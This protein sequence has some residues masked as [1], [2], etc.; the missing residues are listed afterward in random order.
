MATDFR[1]KEQLTDLT[2]QIVESYRD[3]GTINHLG[4]CPLPSTTVIADALQDLKEV[5]YPGYRRRQNLHLGNVTYYAGDLIDSLHD[6]LTEQIAR[7]LRYADDLTADGSCDAQK[8]IDYEAAGQDHAIRLL[9]SLPELRRMLAMDVQAA[10]DGDPA[11]GGLDEIIFCY[12]GLE[13]I[14]IHRIA[15]QLHQQG[16]PLIPRIMAEWS[17]AQTGIDIHPGAR[18]GESFF[19]DHGTGVVIGETTDIAANVKIYQGVTL[20][21]ISFPRDSEGNLLRGAKRHPTIEEGVVIYANA[22]I[23][24]GKTVIGSNSVIG[25]SVS[26]NKSVPPNTLVTIEKPS[27]R[28]REAG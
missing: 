20:G 21:A 15:H 27:L 6:T 9:E 4:H 28:F 18:I 22:T 10:Y 17:H 2:D 23:L 3:I 25:A 7:A 11:A 26:L 13:A 24:G 14:T 12:P 19:I 1:R 5:L 16:V 8:L